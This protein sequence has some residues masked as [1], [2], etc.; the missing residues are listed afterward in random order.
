MLSKPY[1]WATVQMPLNVMDGHFRSFQHQV[2]PELARRGIGPLGMKSLGG[3]GKIVTE[4]GVRV[5]DALRYVL[6]LPIA[7]LV[8]GIDSVKVLEQNLKIAREFKPMTE[9][10]KKDIESRTLKLAGDGRF[11]LFK[12]SKT[13]DGAVHRKQHGF[14]TGTA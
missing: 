8:S 5:E 6:S 3:A 1:D 2:L 13:Y 11:E 14:A 7:S 12:S 10:E 9:S 4:A